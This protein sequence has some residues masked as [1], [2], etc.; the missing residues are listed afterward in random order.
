LKHL[1]AFPYDVCS[2]DFSGSGKS[3]GKFTAY[4]LREKDD[5]SAVLAWLD[6]T[7]SYEE[8][9]LWGRSMGSVAILLSQG[10]LLNPKVSTIILDSPFSSFEK[11]SL[12]IASKKS[13]IPELFL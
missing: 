4:G 8:Y 5:V 10:L 11:V 6:E 7:Q 13:F 12:E 1:K 2:F 9:I 3:E